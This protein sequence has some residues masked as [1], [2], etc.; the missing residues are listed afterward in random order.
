MRMPHFPGN[1]ETVSDLLGFD[2]SMNE[3]DAL[4]ESGKISIVEY[5]TLQRKMN[6]LGRLTHAEMVEMGEKA[7]LKIDA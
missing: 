3:L 2:D 5:K 1:S 6:E 4:M 7:H